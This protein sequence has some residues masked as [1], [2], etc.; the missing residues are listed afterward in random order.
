MSSKQVKLTPDQKEKILREIWILHDGR[1]FLKSIKEFGF[2]AATELNIAVTKSFGKTEMKRL[3]SEIGY[4]K[5]KNIEELKALMEIAADLYFPEDHKHEFKILSKDSLLGHV[6]E[7]Y[8]YK[9]VNKAGISHI[10]QCAAKTR[11][12]SWREAFDLEGEILVDKN[13]DN[14]NGSCQI[15]FNIKW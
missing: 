6:L 13:T 15:I 4:S 5:I 1:W 10:H 2:D 12:D 7:C 8:V 11:F 9:N 14:C 3:L